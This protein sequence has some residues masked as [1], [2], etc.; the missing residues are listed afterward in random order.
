MNRLTT[1]FF[2]LFLLLAGC[3]SSPKVPPKES[4]PGSDLALP[5][6]K[7]AARNTTPR[8]TLKKGGGY[9]LDDGPSDETPDNLDDIP[10]A[11]P[12][13]EPLHKPAMRPYVVLGRQYI[14][15]T[16]VK[17]YKTRGIASWYGKKFH[18]QKTSIGE[19]YNMFAMTAAHT[20]LAIPSYVRV[21]NPRNGK[22]VVVR[23]NDR[24]PFHAGRIIDLSYTAA[25]KLDIIN[26]G[27]SEVEVEAILPSGAPA[28][29]GEEVS[30]RRPIEIP[31]VREQRDEIAE[32]MKR[33]EREET[34]SNTQKGIFLQLGAFARSDNAENLKIHLA[35]ELDWLADSL[36]IQT[37]GGIHRLQVGPYPTRDDAL[38]VA[39]RI[40]QALGTKPA[41]VVR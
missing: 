33:V 38:R 13:V 24:G 7:S 2:L 30:A 34:R 39:E 32:L 23:V 41:L 25:Y 40:R 5:E 18:G 10:D 28:I 27:S 17:P 21:S 3:G 29:P 35:S 9:Y 15:N 14:P 36:L 12:K 6:Y 4:A 22:S 8:P 16:E 19:P 37:S 31:T 20:T 26:N 11:Q 1:A